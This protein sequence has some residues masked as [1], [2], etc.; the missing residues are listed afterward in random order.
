MTSDDI[1]RGSLHLARHD[2]IPLVGCLLMQNI[3]GT[4]PR[5]ITSENIGVQEWVVISPD[6]R[7]VVV[8]SVDG[9]LVLQP[10]DDGKPKE[11]PK[12]TNGF[13]P[14]RWCPDNRSLLVYQ[15]GTM[16]MKITKV[17]VETGTQAVWKEWVL[18]DKVGFDGSY[19]IKVSRDCQSLAY[20]ALYNPSELW[21]ADGFR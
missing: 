4:P 13:M 19:S 5:A 2:F 14:L 17:D 15:P 9:K 10:L 16:P 6:G 11:I 20:T 7:F 1:P 8:N 18:A 21:I 3:D 12:L